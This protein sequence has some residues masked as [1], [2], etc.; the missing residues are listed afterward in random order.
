MY[1]SSMDAGNV[2]VIVRIAILSSL[3]HPEGPINSCHS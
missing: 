1:V 3:R 2:T